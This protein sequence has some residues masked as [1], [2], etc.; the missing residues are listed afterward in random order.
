MKITLAQ[1]YAHTL[2][3]IANCI[4]GGNDE[5]L[6]RWPDRLSHLNKMMPSGSGLDCGVSLDEDASTPLSLVFI[7]PYHQ[8]DEHGSYDGWVDNTLT[9]TP[10]FG[11]PSIDWAGDN[12]DHADYIC[13]AILGALREERE[14][15][16]TY[17]ADWFTP[18]F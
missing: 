5:W 6:T 4:A 16:E 2:Q 17:P 8:M 14:I 1:A 15:S 7:A 12:E 18:K 9:V 13:D 3:A 11:G 10:T